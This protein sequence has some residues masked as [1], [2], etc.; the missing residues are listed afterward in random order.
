MSEFIIANTL[1]GKIRG[2]KKTT[3]LGDDYFSFQRIPYA[4]PPINELR[5][6]DPQPILSWSE[7]IDGTMQT[8]ICIQRSTIFNRIVGDEDCLYL[9]IY[10]KNLNP[11]I[12]TPVMIFIHGGGFMYGTS[13]SETYGPDYILKKNVILVT[14]NYR[15]G[16]FGECEIIFN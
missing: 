16:I 11:K 7:A 1:N 4:K 14:I 8:P 10:T 6:T 5:F 15:V 3:V 9:N 2:V 12:K 13:G